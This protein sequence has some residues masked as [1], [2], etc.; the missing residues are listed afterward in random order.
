MHLVFY[1]M[2]QSLKLCSFDFSFIQSSWPIRNQNEI[3]HE[4]FKSITWFDRWNMQT[5]RHVISLWFH[6]VLLQEA[7][8]LSALKS[9][10]CQ[11][12]A[13]NITEALN[14][15]LLCS[16]SYYQF[17]VTFHWILPTGKITSLGLLRATNYDLL[18]KHVNVICYNKNCGDISLKMSFFL[19]FFLSWLI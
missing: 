3:P 10:A 6:S 16:Y 7:L 14:S 5:G 12:C 15:I 4:K 13:C 18:W 9:Y 19:S 1:T 11:A 17:Q 8:K 2:S